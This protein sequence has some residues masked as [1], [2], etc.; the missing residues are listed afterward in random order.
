MTKKTFESLPSEIY[1]HIGKYVNTNSIN[2][3]SYQKFKEDHVYF[4]YS[5]V[6]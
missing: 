3:K 4:Y 5:H 1:G 2:K 6:N